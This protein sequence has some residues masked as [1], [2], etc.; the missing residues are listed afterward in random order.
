MIKLVVMSDTHNQ[1]DSIDVPDGD[2]L[3]HAG[4]ATGR[5]SIWEV[6]A[7]NDWLGKLPHKVKIAISGNHDYFYEQH[8]SDGLPHSILYNGFYLQDSSKI[9]FNNGHHLNIYGSPWT[10]RYYDWAFNLDRG[11]QI[12]EKWDMIPNGI[13]ILVTH[14]PPF[15]HGDRT[16]AGHYVGCQD[17][18][19][20]VERI[21][22][23]L[24]IF[25]HI[26]EGYGISYNADTVFINASICDR[27]YRPVNKPIVYEI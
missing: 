19:R 7:F 17:L 20:A 11:P 27:T 25:G 1:H 4:D 2:I 15:G 14:G 26:H 12:K 13:D 5:G 9:Y 21:K 22:P 23:K 16:D 3:I 18:L 10:C 8:M 6:K 24:H